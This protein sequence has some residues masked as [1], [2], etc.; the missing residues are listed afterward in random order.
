MLDFGY[1]AQTRDLNRN[2]LCAK[3]F[4]KYVDN[5]F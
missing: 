4:Q 1:F 5:S 3:F 2:A